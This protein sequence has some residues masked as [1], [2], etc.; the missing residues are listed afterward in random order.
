MQQKGWS[1]EQPKARSK[2]DGHR[3]VE[4]QKSQRFIPSLQTVF[5]ISSTIRMASDA[6]SVL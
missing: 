3:Q 6:P 2:V 5:Q 1:E 4:I